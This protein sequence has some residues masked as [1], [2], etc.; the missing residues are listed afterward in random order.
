MQQIG[1]YLVSI[2]ATAFLCSI[3]KQITA[4]LNLSSKWIH[5][6]AGVLM[7]IVLISPIKKI[8]LGLVQDFSA[9][10]IEEGQYY[11]QMGEQIA[12]EQTAEFIKEH[13]R[14]YILEKASSLNAK[15]EVDVLLS[16]SQLPIPCGVQI[17]G[18]ISPYARQ[19]LATYICNELG[20]PE[21]N[22]VW[23]QES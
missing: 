14:T 11:A 23:I 3:L 21:E 22:Q 7:A 20:V 16:E 12:A 19:V 1:N 13:V 6:L 8:S 15:V 18:E 4:K 10:Y 9:D 2:C 5:M 17:Q